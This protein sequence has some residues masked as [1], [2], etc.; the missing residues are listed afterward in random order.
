MGGGGPQLML[1]IHQLLTRRGDGKKS[2]PD[3]L[4]KPSNIKSDSNIDS[5][6]QKALSGQDNQNDSLD[7]CIAAKE[8]GE[9]KS[10]KGLLIFISELT[11][12]KDSEIRSRAA[13]ALV[14]FDS[15]K[16][17][18]PLL[19]ALT[20]NSKEVR[21]SAANALGYISS[22]NHGVEKN[23][24]L[25][26]L[27]RSERIVDS[28][29]QVLNDKDNSYKNRDC[30]RVRLLAISALGSLAKDGNLKTE[31]AVD[32]LLQ[33]LND[34]DRDIRMASAVS[35][36]SI[37]SSRAAESLIQ[38]LNDNDRFVRGNAAEALG[39][40]KSKKAI[41]PL[42]QLA[43]DDTDQNVRSWAEISLS[44]IDEKI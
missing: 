38:A 21:A 33:T 3:S 13:E 7:R 39:K 8:L 18:D 2:S 44:Q 26:S 10:E 29:I 15:E 40:I 16:S 41:E 35:L 17:I 11:T 12:N 14:H 28:L 5:L 42:R 22:R 24:V 43:V 6:V 32:S 20:D 30:W 25:K 4:P 19:Q 36:G 34:D 1:L 23:C 31:K 27:L 9:L 37:G